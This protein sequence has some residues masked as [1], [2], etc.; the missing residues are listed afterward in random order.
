MH[1]PERAYADSDQRDIVETLGADDANAEQDAL[2]PF[3]S[4]V[5]RRAAGLVLAGQYSGGSQTFGAVLRDAIS[6]HSV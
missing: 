2:P 1:D 6:R 5:R 4:L 3:K